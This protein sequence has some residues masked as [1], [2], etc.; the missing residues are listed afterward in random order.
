MR[1]R[2]IG[3]VE[4][5]SSSADNSRIVDVYAGCHAASSGRTHPRRARQPVLRYL[6]ATR[7]P[8]LSVTFVGVLIGWASAFADGASFSA[9]PAALTMIFALVA[10]AG[11]NVI[12]DYYDSV[13][14]CDA[15]NVERLFPVHRRQ[16]V[17][18]ERRPDPASGEGC[19]AM[20]C[21]QR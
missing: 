21:S 3:L 6:M 7:P 14:G 20:A 18:P 2:K 10:H 9:L 15:A 19:S 5:M 1:C 12:N 13:N 11:A 8:F 4:L 16:P 17:H